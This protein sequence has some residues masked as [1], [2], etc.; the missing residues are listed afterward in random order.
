MAIFYEAP[1]PP[2]DLTTF[3]REVP[4]PSNLAFLV[5][6]PARYLTTNTVDFSEILR[7]NRAAK[8]RTFDGRITVSQRDGGSDKRVPLIPLSTSLSQ[9]E[10]E[11]LKLEFARTGGTRSEALANATYNDGE[12]LTREVQNRL[13]LAWGDLLTDGKITINENGVNGEYDFG[14]PANHLVTAAT[15]WSNIAAP[16]LDDMIAWNDEYRRTNGVRPGAQRTTEGVLRLLQRNTQIVNAVH[17]AQTGKTRVTFSELNDLLDS[18][19]LAPIVLQDVA[20]FDVDGVI[21]PVIPDDRVMLTPADLADLGYTAFGVSATALELVDSEKVEF[22][23][24]NA[25]GIVGVTEKVGPPYREFTYVDATALPIL[26]DAK[27]L[28]VA[29]VR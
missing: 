7:T 18:E 17:G 6:F 10:Y 12:Q 19:N 16:A 2:V 5:A 8:F 28:F 14:V 24:E 13:E 29:K 15:L 22:S 21:T 9:G 25:P 27:R 4:V 11:R 1:V 3:I 20:R 23:F 26:S